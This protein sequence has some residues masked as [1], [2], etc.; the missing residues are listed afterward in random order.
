MNSKPQIH[1]FAHNS[2]EYDFQVLPSYNEH[3]G[4]G[5]KHNLVVTNDGDFAG[6][7]D[8]ST[9]HA[10]R[11]V[12][13]TRQSTF[14]LFPIISPLLSLTCSLLFPFAFCWIHQS[15]TSSPSSCSALPNPEGQLLQPTFH[16][17]TSH[18]A[19]NAISPLN[20][21]QDLKL[22]PIMYGRRGCGAESG[23]CRKI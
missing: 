10:L 15:S 9:A 11:L 16:A 13:W 18:S 14:A 22:W 23:L 17:R 1:H 19:C 8:R 2:R 12:D 20:H 7:A 6:E 4:E 21:N 5:H 3:L